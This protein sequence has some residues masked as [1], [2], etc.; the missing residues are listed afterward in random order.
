MKISTLFPRLAFAL[1]TFLFLTPLLPSYWGMVLATA[2]VLGF[3]ALERTFRRFSFLNF[4]TLILGL[5]IGYLFGQVFL[6]IFNSLFAITLSL[7]TRA[8]EMMQ[9]FC[10]LGGLYLGITKTFAASQEFC[11]SLPFVRL[12]TNK[13]TIKDILVD[14]SALSDPRLIELAL[15]GLLDNRLMVPRFL[16]KDLYEQEEARDETIQARARLAIEVLR[17]LESIPEL[18]LRYNDTDFPE[19]KEMMP[20]ML[21]LARLLNADVL[22]TD[23]NRVQ[24]A[25]IEGVRIVN[26]HALSNALKPL[27]QRGEYLSIKI[28][29]PGKEE[30]QGVG[31]LEDGT[32]IVVNGAGE[33]VGRSI[34]ACVLSVKHTTTGR[35]IF[36]N[37]AA[38]Q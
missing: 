27:M 18:S 30:R 22:T 32:M 3:F 8:L 38:D 35:M 21:H 19:V 13:H 15:S 10:L 33:F 11:V 34:K 17:K 20:K 12:Q 16:L 23:I 25:S 24:M 9:L 26:L 1:L 7:E 29:R 5:F 14:P 36:C 4:N 37:V 31:Y 28:Q 6:L 2:T